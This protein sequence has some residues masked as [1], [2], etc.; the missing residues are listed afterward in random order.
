MVAL[1][2][3]KE[4]ASLADDM[5]GCEYEYEYSNDMIMRMKGGAKALGDLEQIGHGP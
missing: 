5:I 2:I 3:N 4:V 1:S